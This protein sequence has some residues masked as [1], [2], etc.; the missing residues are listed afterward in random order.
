MLQV[1]RNLTDAFD[2]FLL[3][4]RYLILDRD[5]KYTDA[6][7]DFM[8]D[9]GTKIVRVP[10]R[11]PNLNAHRPPPLPSGTTRSRQRPFDIGIRS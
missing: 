10:A 3:E 9:S 5:S 2:G 1:A 7:R 11:S 8:T 4:K 6:F